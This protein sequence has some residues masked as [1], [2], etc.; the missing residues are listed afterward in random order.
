MSDD[1]PT[2]PVLSVETIAPPPQNA[3]ALKVAMGEKGVLLRN[4][5]DLIRFG[6]LAVSSGAA[7]RGM[8]EGAAALAIQAGL[9]RGLGVLGGL[10]ACV[11]IN[12]NLSWRG[13]AA[14]A[15]IQ[16]SPAC[17]TGTLRFWAD[18]SGEE[19]KGVAV[20]KRAGYQ[21]ADR[22]EF[23]VA[24]ARRAHL[25]GKAGPWTEY[26]ANMLMWR[27]L[28]KLANEVFPDVMGGFPLAEEAQD[29]EAPPSSPAERAAMLPPPKPDPLMEALGVPD[30][31]SHSDVD[32]AAEP[33]YPTHAEAD[34]AIAAQ[35]K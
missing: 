8:S 23:T 16:N 27:A 15:L 3:A 4:L 7:P 21:E 35:E 13:K 33:P 20:A 10:Q 18:G 9:E 28:G 31:A 26:P 14:A 2:P 11:V 5:D 6:R 29:F 30:F 32:V 24:D 1:T 34:A 19:A 25:W 17:M 12:G 22:R